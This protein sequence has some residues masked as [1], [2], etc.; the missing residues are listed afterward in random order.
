[1]TVA[2]GKNRTQTLT[3]GIGGLTS[4]TVNPFSPLEFGWTVDSN[5][6][7]AKQIAAGAAAASGSC[8]LAATNGC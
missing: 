4:V 3:I 2:P 1:M 7:T 8:D 5:G 6:T